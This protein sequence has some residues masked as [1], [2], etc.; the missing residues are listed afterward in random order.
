MENVSGRERDVRKEF[1]AGALA[2]VVVAAAPPAS[3]AEGIAWNGF[4]QSHV[5]AR[6]SNVQCPAGTECDLP[7]AEL[8][9]QLEGEG[10]NAAGNAGFLGRFNLIRDIALGDTR[11]ET[12]ELYADARSESLAA[13]LG[14]QVITWGVGDLLFIND[15]FPKD[16]VA[17]FTGQPLQYLKLGSDALK[18]NAYPG[19][20]NLELLIARFRPDNLPTSRRF[21]LT[22]PLPAGL[23]RSTT[24]PGAHAAELEISGRISGYLDNWELAG[25]ASRTHYRS[26]ALRVTAG[27]IVGIYPR[28]NTLGG[29]LTGPVGKGVLS[30]E[31]GYY[32][33]PS[34]RDGRDPSIENSQFRGLVGF[35]RQL[36]EDTTLGLQL[37]GEWMRNY[38]AYLET[39]PAGFSA[40]DRLRQVATFRFTQL[41]AHQTLTFNVFAFIGLSEKDRYVIPSLRYNFSDNLWAEIGANVFAGNRSGTYGA[42]QD[43]RNVYLT[44]RFAI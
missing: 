39:L 44:V 2:A 36:W 17:L 9:G 42:L 3:A 25:Y 10:K 38:S 33:S 27:Q 40:K 28:L 19:P 15:T 35:S 13:R 22:D 11:L 14:R 7:V 21:I 37:Y 12:R 34:D 31:G 23:P 1:L 43:N 41:F 5:V 4:V 29:S 20:A 26:P 8:R 24:E 6:T 30:L 18:L 16:R 32:D